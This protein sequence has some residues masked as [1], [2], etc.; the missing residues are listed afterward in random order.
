MDVLA[1]A[2]LIV[3][4]VTGLNGFLI[5]SLSISGVFGL[6]CLIDSVNQSEKERKLEDENK[7]FGKDYEKI[8]SKRAKDLLSFIFYVIMIVVSIIVLVL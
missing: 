7:D 6:I 5:A 8:K 1:L 2:F 3:G 4:C